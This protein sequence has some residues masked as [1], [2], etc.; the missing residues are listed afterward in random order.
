MAIAD[1]HTGRRRS[2][3]NAL[4]KARYDMNRGRAVNA[5]EITRASV[6]AQ[7]QSQTAAESVQTPANASVQTPETG[8][9]EGRYFV[10]SLPTHSGSSFVAYR[11]QPPI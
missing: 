11:N 3:S 4:G 6:W 1:P 5:P 8:R 9:W 2:P 10:M 7:P